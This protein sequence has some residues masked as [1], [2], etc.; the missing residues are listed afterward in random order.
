MEIEAKIWEAAHRA[1]ERGVALYLEDP[2]VTLIDLGYR[3][4]TSEGNRI[5]PDLTVRVHVRQKLTGSAFTIFAAEEPDRVIT[6]ERLGFP[7]EVLP[8]IY[9]LQLSSRNSS[10]QPEHAKAYDQLCGGLSISGEWRQSFGTLGGKVRDRRTGEELLLSAWHVLSGT[11]NKNFQGAIYQPAREHDS[12]MRPSIAEYQRGAMTNHLDAAVAQ[13]THQRPLFNTQ[14]G[15]GNVTGV[16]SP[17]IGMQVVKSGCGTGVTKGLITGIHGYSLQRYAGISHLI[18][19]IVQI[20]PETAEGKICAYGD[21]GAWW[22]ECATRRAVAMHFAGSQQPNLAI[23]LAMP[24]VL[25]ALDVDIVTTPESEAPI[26]ISPI[27]LTPPGE[28]LVALSEHLPTSLPQVIVVDENLI[29]QQEFLPLPLPQVATS[30]EISAKPLEHS[31]P[32]EAAVEEAIAGSAKD[33]LEE[34]PVLAKAAPSSLLLPVPVSSR[35]NTLVTKTKLRDAVNWYIGFTNFQTKAT[36]LSRRLKPALVSLSQKLASL[37]SRSR[38]AEVIETVEIEILTEEAASKLSP[39]KIIR[40]GRLDIVSSQKFFGQHGYSVAIAAVIAMILIP[41][42]F[43]IAFDTFDSR[44]Q[45]YRQA[46]E[47]QLHHLQQRLQQVQSMTE[48]DALRE[49]RI[50]KI[51]LIINRFN[52]EMEGFTKYDLAC[53]IVTLSQKYKQLDPDL[54][55][56]TISV[57]TRWNPEAVSFAGAM[58][59]MQI[60]PSTAITVAKAD[61]MIWTSPEEILFDPIANTRLGCQ[62]LAYLVGKYGLEAGLAG[63]NAGEGWARLW[64]QYGH[65]PPGLPDETLAYVPNIL[66]LYR[67]F[68]NLKL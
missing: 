31:L 9:R 5:E 33:I 68:Q 14:L 38:T 34:S 22:L 37:V 16:A 4:H 59:I 32:Q 10:A 46:R 12:M 51:N 56:A 42:G 35:Q 27:E 64:Q 49:R 47:Q 50:N 1:L 45:E 53:A 25:A 17:Q 54:I 57:E 23:A 24:E 65:A 48:F 19:H 29:E 3:L 11:K 62:H 28:T 21:S 61:G 58:G 40:R 43:M 26:I 52:P 66:K 55:C 63:Y 13:L 18:R 67:T 41:G 7:V 30:N 39:N 20:T 15:L 36:I 2:N 6:A 44:L 8:A 60:L